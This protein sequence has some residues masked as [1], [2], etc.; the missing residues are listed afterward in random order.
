MRDGGEDEWK[1]KFLLVPVEG[2]QTSWWLVDGYGS[3]MLKSE[4]ACEGF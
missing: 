1:R 3:G 2:E 4:T